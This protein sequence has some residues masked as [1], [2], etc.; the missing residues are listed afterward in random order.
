MNDNYLICKSKY[1]AYKVKNQLKPEKKFYSPSMPYLETLMQNHIEK[2][3]LSV[4]VFTALQAL[5]VK[6][7]EVTVYD[8]L[9]NGQEHIHAYSIT[10]ENGIIPDIELPVQHDP[11]HLFGS[12][13]YHFT[14]YNI[15]VTAENF[16][17]VNVLNFRIF[18]GEKTNYTIEML[19]VIPGET[20]HTPE[21]TIKVPNSLIDE[22]NY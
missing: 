10:D 5:P 14:I 18:P 20:I 16:Y 22:Q 11:M 7:A 15:R 3:T 19:P 21:Q 2:G 9:E 6:N 4:R 17:P 8:V 13:K 12:P 1:K